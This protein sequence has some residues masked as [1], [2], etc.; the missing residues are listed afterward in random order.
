[1]AVPRS[2]R[3]SFAPACALLLMAG[4]GGAPPE[5]TPSSAATPTAVPTATPVVVSL[6]LSTGELEFGEVQ[7]GAASTLTLN[8]VNDGNVP[9][10]LDAT[11][12]TGRNDE[13]FRVTG[14]G[15][16]DP[17][18]S[19]ALTVTFAPVG[20]GTAQATFT[21]TTTPEEA[22]FT[23]TASGTGG[24][25]DLDNDGECSLDTGGDDCN[26]SNNNT[27]PGAD[28]ICDGED[29]DCDQEI[30]NDAID[31]DSFYRDT[32]GDGYG[33]SQT[34]VEACE[35]PPGRDWADVGRDCDDTNPEINPGA[36][37]LCDGLDNNCDNQIDN[38]TDDDG[39]GTRDCY[40]D[41]G[42]G[43]C[44]GATCLDE[45]AVGGD[46][47][48]LA[49]TSNPG[50][51]EVPSDGRDNNCNGDIDENSPPRV[52]L[53][54]PAE[55]G[56]L[57]DRSTPLEIV[58]QAIDVEDGPGVVVQVESD[59]D[60]VLCEGE[61]D[62][63]SVYTCQTPLSFGA[64]VLTASAVDSE[65]ASG[66]DSLVVI[67]DT[68]PEVSPVYPED[69]EEIPY[70]VTKTFIALVS[71]DDREEA[72]ASFPFTW[73]SDRDGVIATGFAADGFAQASVSLVSEGAHVLTLT[74]TDT[75]GGTASIT[76]PVTVSEPSCSQNKGLVALYHFDESAGLTAADASG[77]G[78]D[79]EL[80]ETMTWQ[81]GNWGGGLGFNGVD[82]YVRI[83]NTDGQLSLNTFTIETRVRFTT[84]APLPLIARQP[85]IFKGSEEATTQENYDLRLN[86]N[87]TLQV[88]VEKTTAPPPSDLVAT[89]TS[90][91]SRETW[92]Q[93]V[94]TYDG[95]QLKVYVNGLLEGTT[96]TGTVS[97]R[98]GSAPLYL[99][100]DGF[101]ANPQPRWLNGVLDE[102]RILDCALSEQQISADYGRGE[103]YVV[104][105]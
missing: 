16:V 53:L 1:M 39:D 87:G 10:T 51:D 47:D 63:T 58:V 76:V 4:C 105:P 35:P 37:E 12:V 95:A 7:Q 62:G 70:G 73:T 71:D 56:G 75:V 3:R 94:A 77:N 97:L 96:A 103:P 61:T 74:V 20:S 52:T 36:Q 13:W 104:S 43:Y 85:L 2:L 44:E 72:S 80:S 45:T 83:P 101:S 17:D 78:L 50:A 92:Y 79:A 11:S 19:R 25:S 34:R 38:G 55:D 26:D 24:C 65:G 23:F 102:V 41:D 66:G 29:N 42:D 32:D 86:Q 98:Q 60:G 81:S 18:D 9:V 82:A 54:S 21:V 67:A 33:N 93:V 100:T 31:A 84:P 8:V 69:G 59:V 27:Y 88:Q 28:E 57:V 22:G 5:P 46:C 90:T 48:D 99:G 14:L 64:H 15:V 49:A 89:G 91:F 68:A 40:D 6:S 30:D